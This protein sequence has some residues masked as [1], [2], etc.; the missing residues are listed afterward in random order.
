[1]HIS[2]NMITL[3][4]YEQL[5]VWET[6]AL[7]LI[8]SLWSGAFLTLCGALYTDISLSSSPVVAVVFTYLSYDCI[9]HN[10][11]FHATCFEFS[12]NLNS[13]SFPS[14]GVTGML[15]PCARCPL[16][17]RRL[18]LTI[19]AFRHSGCAHSLLCGVFFSPL[20]PSLCPSLTLPLISS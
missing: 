1:M 16:S 19:V 17:R 15:A 8:K 9:L 6:L 14:R 4:I 12:L 5:A 10:Q 7:S 2:E 11:L 13:S 3:F 18:L 20:S